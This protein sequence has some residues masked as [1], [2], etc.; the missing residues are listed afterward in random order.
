MINSPGCKRSHSFCARVINEGRSPNP[1]P[2]PNPGVGY[3]VSFGCQSSFK[4]YPP[5]SPPHPISSMGRST[6]T[7]PA[8]FNEMRSAAGC[9]CSLVAATSAVNSSCAGLAS[10]TGF[11]C[12]HTEAAQQTEPARTTA[13]RRT[14]TVF[15]LECSQTVDPP[16]ATLASASK[17]VLTDRGSTTKLRWRIQ[18]VRPMRQTS[19][20]IPVNVPFPQ[21]RPPA[22][23]DLH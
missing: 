18:N 23:R 1:L 13:L 19:R 22:Q 16:K 6:A 5:S 7:F 4:S 10:T 15:H 21:T 11:T 3:F 20:R 8:F 12:A 17:R 2:H 9:P 14:F